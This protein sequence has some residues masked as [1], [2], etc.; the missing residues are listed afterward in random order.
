MVTQT[1]SDYLFVYGTLRPSFENPFAGYLRQHSRYTGEGTFP[2]LLFDLG[3]YP[4][5]VF[6]QSGRQNVWGSVYHIK[7]HKQAALTYLDEYEGV[8]SGFTQPAEYVRAL[9]PVSMNQTVLMS[10]VYLYN[11][12][13]VDKPVISSGDYSH[14]R[15]G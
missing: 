5:A 4:G 2:G 10:W 8:G 9:V 11:L 13:L 1:D 15:K 7:Q 12:S 6:Q 14:Y 3:N